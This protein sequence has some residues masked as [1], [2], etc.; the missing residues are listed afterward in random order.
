MAQYLVNG[1]F[2][3]AKYYANKELAETAYNHV[4]H[5]Q[6][7][8]NGCALVA[9]NRAEC[10]V[11]IFKEVEVINNDQSSIANLWVKAIYLLGVF[12]EYQGPEL[13]YRARLGQIGD[14]NV[15][16]WKWL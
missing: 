6:I 5:W 1:A 14:W 7:E 11:L 4:Y 3:W 13:G 16:P 12:Y 15:G 2:E 9:P 8:Q 10:V